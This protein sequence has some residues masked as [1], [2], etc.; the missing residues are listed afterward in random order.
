MDVGEVTPGPLCGMLEKRAA[1]PSVSFLHRLYVLMLERQMMG[2][3][4]VLKDFESQ[5]DI[6]E[7][8]G[9]CHPCVFGR[10]SIFGND[11]PT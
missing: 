4:V 11:L 1:Y 6:L 8:L 9:S 2:R 7:L 3:M 5:R 10:A